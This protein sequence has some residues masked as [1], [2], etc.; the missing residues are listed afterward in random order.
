MITAMFTVH[1]SNGFFVSNGGV[2]NVLILFAVTLSLTL[3][4]PGK[5]A[6]SDMI[7]ARRAAATPEAA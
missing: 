7:F 2:S 4:G 3:T 1:L 5:L 6:L